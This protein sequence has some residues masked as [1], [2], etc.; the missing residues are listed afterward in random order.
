MNG[1]C[2]ILI[3]T[4][5]ED[6]EE[7]DTRF[8]KFAPSVHDEAGSIED[9]I[10]SLGE[11][12]DGVLDLFRR[13]QSEHFQNIGVDDE[14]VAGSKTI[15]RPGLTDTQ[16]QSTTA[17]E[18]TRVFSF[19]S[20]P[21]VIRLSRILANVYQGPNSLYKRPRDERFV[22][23]M[24]GNGIAATDFSKAINILSEYGTPEK[25]VCATEAYL[26]EHFEPLIGDTAIQDLARI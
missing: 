9:I 26:K 24:N 23:V 14:I 7:L 4:K 22:L 25:A 13:I 15:G 20:L 17:D 10:E 16:S 11:G 6:P 8:A 19:D 18:Q 12:A 21:V 3:V 1:E 5:V 2:L